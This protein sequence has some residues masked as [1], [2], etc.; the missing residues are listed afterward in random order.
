MTQIF[1]PTWEKILIFIEHRK[2]V[3]FVL[4]KYK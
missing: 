2:Y 3:N 1:T 4:I